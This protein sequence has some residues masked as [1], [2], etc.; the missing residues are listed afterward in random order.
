MNKIDSKRRF[1]SLW[2][3]LLPLE[4]ITKHRTDLNNLPLCVYLESN[5]DKIIC[6]NQSARNLGI[7]VG[8]SPKEALILSPKA[9]NKMIEGLKLKKE[10]IS[11]CDYIY[12]FTPTIGLDGYDGLI[13]DITGC[14]SF[15]GSEKKFANH[16]ITLTF[17][18]KKSLLL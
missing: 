10:L 7:K 11:F 17:L 12:K 5:K 16:L 4:T 14:K 9:V 13:L 18:E 2:F 8:M 1:V 3:P 6:T 15:T